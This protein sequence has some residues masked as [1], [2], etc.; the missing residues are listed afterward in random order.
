M[1][2]DPDMTSNSRHTQA[3]MESNYQLC[4]TREHKQ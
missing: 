4:S 3:T 1:Y 2:I